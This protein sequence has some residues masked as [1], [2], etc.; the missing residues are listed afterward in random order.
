[1]LLGCL[2]LRVAG[3]FWEHAGAAAD[4]GWARVRDSG[5]G[6]GAVGRLEDRG[7]DP[8]RGGLACTV[9]A[10]H[11]EDLPLLGG[12]GEV[13]EGDERAVTL[14]NAV[15][16]DGC[17]HAPLVTETSSLRSL[18]P[19][20][21]CSRTVPMPRT[22]SLW[23]STPGSSGVHSWVSSAFAT[24]DAV[25]GRHVDAWLGSVDASRPGARG[26]CDVAAGIELGGLLAEVPDVAIRV[27]AVPVGC[28]LAQSTAE[29]EPIV[30]DDARHAVDR[31][32]LVGD[33]EDVAR[34][35]AV[36]DAGVDVAG[37]RLERIP[38]VV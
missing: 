33:G 27:L 22:Y 1:V 37:A 10:E 9:R 12:E 36:L 25:A 18:P 6:E 38:L 14:A 31:L 11:A 3:A 17:G 13:L 20:S 35:L 16:F 7:E 34:G 30:D 21:V 32:R 15:R 23:S 29:I 24:C 2:S 28:L 8:D 19:F 4:L 5:D 26:A